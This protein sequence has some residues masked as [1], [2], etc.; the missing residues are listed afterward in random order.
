[1]VPN[2]IDAAL[3]KNTE[4]P[5]PSDLL[6]HYDYGAA[7]I[8]CWGRGTEVLE[9]RA[10][11]PRPSVP[12]T[13]PSGTTHDSDA[14]IN[15][16]AEARIPDGAGAGTRGLV[17][18]EGLAMWDEVMLFFWGNTQAAKERYLKKVSEDTQRVEKWREGIPR[19]SA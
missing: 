1:M 6:L 9:N 17:E 12:P 5:K 2:N 19:D 18:S 11:P 15:K 14:A 7:A 8:E 3:R 16:L 4:K 13:G 10:N